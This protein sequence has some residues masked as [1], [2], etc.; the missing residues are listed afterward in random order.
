MAARQWAATRPGNVLD[1]Q[2]A[3]ACRVHT[4]TEQ[5]EALYR[6]GRA[7]E[8]AIGQMDGLETWS[9]CRQAHR[10]G[11]TTGGLAADNV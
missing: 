1:I 9:I 2:V 11:D 10:T 8:R 6:R 3:K 5:F 4:L 7:P